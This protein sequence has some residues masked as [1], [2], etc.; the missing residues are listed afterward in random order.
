MTPWARAAPAA[1]GEMLTVGG[2]GK[3]SLVLAVEMVT[4]I[5][6]RGL[7]QLWLR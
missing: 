4:W 5:G 3:G 1:A 7:R 2:R 6:D